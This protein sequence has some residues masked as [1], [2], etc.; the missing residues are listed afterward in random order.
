MLSLLLTRLYLPKNQL[1]VTCAVEE[2]RARVS[3]LFG[4]HLRYYW[5]RFCV[6]FFVWCCS[7]F[8]T[9]CFCVKPTIIE[10]FIIKVM[11]W[12]VLGKM[13]PYSR[14]RV[15]PGSDSSGG[16][17]AML[18]HQSTTSPL[19]SATTGHH[20]GACRFLRWISKLSPQP[21]NKSGLGEVIYGIT[22]YLVLFSIQCETSRKNMYS[23]F[24]SKFW[25]ILYML[26]HLFF[27][28]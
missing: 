19:R 18:H 13:S 7:G 4:T 9:L 27:F 28:S 14:Y 1:I 20:Q 8:C 23:L 16:L 22:L 2:S 25:V 24:F 10:C 5:V 6:L 21:S 12:K 17:A 11:C 3:Q 26:F 15:V